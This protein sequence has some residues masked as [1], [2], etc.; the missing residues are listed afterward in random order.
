MAFVL[1]KTAQMKIFIAPALRPGRM[2]LAAAVLMSISTSTRAA[3]R[4]DRPG[5]FSK[6]DYTFAKTAAEGGAMEVALGRLAATKAVDP[7]VREFGNRMVT[8]H[9]KA[10]TR[11]NSIAT[12]A[13]AVLP[14]DAE[15]K[16]QKMIAKLDRFTG[17]EFDREY[18]SAMVEDHKKDVKL[19]EE[20]SHE[21]DNT[22]LKAFATETLPTIR[23]HYQMGLDL[24]KKLKANRR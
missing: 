6:R 8:D 11:L 20:A 4:T 19:F 18:I 10:G 21:V 12:Q 23:A 3:D 16:H 24:E 7:G 15:G 14:S 9:G 5:T 1:L 13:N 2:A 17:D 22:E